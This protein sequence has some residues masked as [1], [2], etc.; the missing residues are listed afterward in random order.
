MGWSNPDGVD[1]TP[2]YIGEGEANSFTAS[3]PAMMGDSTVTSSDG[4]RV[5]RLVVAPSSGYI[6][7]D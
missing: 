5:T 3:V 4:H 6:C 7:E 1:F 2:C